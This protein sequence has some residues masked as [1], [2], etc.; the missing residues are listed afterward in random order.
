MRKLSTIKQS[1]AAQQLGGA[2]LTMAA[3]RRLMALGAGSEL[4]Q[5]VTCS[6]RLHE[7]SYWMEEFMEPRRG[8]VAAIVRAAPPPRSRRAPAPP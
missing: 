5:R 1:K 6:A 3:P 8:T 4:P 7:P 2:M